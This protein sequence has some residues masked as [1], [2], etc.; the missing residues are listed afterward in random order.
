MAGDG[1][2]DIRK[3][4]Q[5]GNAAERK[6]RKILVSGC[7]SVRRTGVGS[8]FV[9]RGCRKPLEDGLYE[10]K[11]NDTPLTPLQ[12]DMQRRLGPLYHVVRVRFD[13]VE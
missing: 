6:V 7:E 10:V 12:R 11:V 8:D 5:R 4:A 13:D 2:S 3:N 1:R 9:A